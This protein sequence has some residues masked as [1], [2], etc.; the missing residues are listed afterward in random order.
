MKVKAKELSVRKNPT[1]KSKELAVL[2]KGDSVEILKKNVKKANGYTWHKVRMYLDGDIVSYVDG[3]VASEYLNPIYKNKNYKKVKTIT[4][5][6][7]VSYTI[8]KLTK[9]KTYYV[10]VR[11]YKTVNGKKY[12]S[13]YSSVKT[14]QIKK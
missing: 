6:K 1:T 7:T 12:Y 11:S 3:Y 10:K 5:N 2:L 14:V 13:N 8:T 4:K 9:G